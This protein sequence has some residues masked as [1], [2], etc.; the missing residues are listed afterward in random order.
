VKINQNLFFTL[1]LSLLI[2]TQVMAKKQNTPA[3]VNP[4][5][6]YWNFDEIVDNK[7][8]DQTGNGHDA[9]V[10]GGVLD[11]G[12][13]GKAILFS[14]AEKNFVHAPNAEQFNLPNKQ[15]TIMAWVKP[16]GLNQK[17]TAGIVNFPNGYAM[18]I[19]NNRLTYADSFWWDFCAF[20]SYGQ[21]E[22]N[23]WQHLAAVRNGDKV[24][25][26][27]DGKEIG[28]RIATGDVKQPSKAEITMGAQSSEVGYFDGWI[29]E[30]AIFGTALT[31]NAIRAKAMQGAAK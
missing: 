28:T 25:L 17:G 23:K 12:K 4:L 16:R 22:L 24:T 14:A 21:L 15:H 27:I 13:L 26:Y 5:I 10:S 9:K 1:V 31:P 18:A 2:S 8:K 3:M 11:E 6:A 30:V 7:I 19:T 20:G 29:D